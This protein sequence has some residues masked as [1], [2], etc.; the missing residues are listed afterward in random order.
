MQDQ[1]TIKYKPKSIIAANARN[2][3]ILLILFV[4]ILIFSMS[5]VLVNNANNE[6]AKNLLSTYSVDASQI[7]NLYVN[8]DITLVRKVSNSKAVSN[9]FS[10]EKNEEKKAIAYDEMMDYA[11]SLDNPHFY[12]G[13]DE[14]KNQYTILSERTLV[15]LSQYGKLDPLYYDDAWYFDCI[16]SDN[17]YVINIDIDKFSYKIKLWINHKVF[18]N[19]SISGVFCSGLEIPELFQKVFSNNKKNKLQ[20]YVI[21]K[22]GII[23]IDNSIHPIEIF[24]KKNSILEKNLN[25]NF[26]SA[27]IPYLNNINGYFSALPE[28]TLVRLSKYKYEYAAICPIIDTDWSIVIFYSGN[29]FSGISNIIPFVLIIILALF[30]YFAFSSALIKNLVFTPLSHLTRNVNEIKSLNVSFFGSEREDEIGELSR[31]ITK[32]TN[33]QYHQEM[34]LN[35]V[36][37]AA[38]ELLLSSTN[39]E[40]FSSSILE[41]MGHIGGTLDVDRVYIY[42]NENRNDGLYYVKKFEWTNK[43]DSDFLSSEHILPIGTALKYT[44]ESDWETI[45]F[46]KNNLNGPIDSLS[47]NNK[48]FLQNFNIKSILMIPIHFHDSFWGFVGF[49]DCHQ[50]RYFSEDEVNILRSVGLMIVSSINRN[51]Q[52]IQLQQANNAKSSFLARMSHEMRTPLNAIIGLSEIILKFSKMDYDSSTNLEKIYNAGVTLLSTVNHILDISKIEA[53]KFE[54]IPVEYDLPSLLNDSISQCI[55]YKGEKPIKFNLSIDEK[56]PARL[57]GDDL[58]IKQ[59]LNN[60]LSNAFKYTRTGTVELQVNCEK[61]ISDNQVCIV[62]NVRDS[63]IGIHMENIENLFT[64]YEQLDTK[65]NRQIEGTGLG[66]PIT[67]KIVEMMDGSISINSEYGKGSTFTVKFIQK[68]VNDAVIGYEVANNLTNFIYSDQKRRKNST[69]QRLQLPYARVLVVDDVET[70]LDVA[71]GMLRPYGIKVDC[72]S[73]GQAAI[74]AIRNE[75]VIYNSILMDQMMPDMDGIETTRIIREEIG[76]EYAKTIPI[77]ALTANA[78]VGTEESFLNKGFQAFLSKPI[79]MEQLDS[80]INAWIRNPELEKSLEKTNPKGQKFL[81]IRCGKERREISSRR[82][83][84]DRRLIETKV[85]GVNIKKGIKRFNNEEETY[86]KVLRSYVLNARLYLKDPI[87]IS[88]DN[89]EKY[90][91]TM[92]GFKGAS[93]GICADFIAAKAEALEKAAKNMNFD[94]IKTNNSDFEND[95]NILANGLDKMLELTKNENK[96]AKENK[97]DPEALKKLLTAC[98][99]YDMDKV[100]TAIEEIDKY[101]YEEDSELAAWL[102][103]NAE[104]ANFIGIIEK[105]KGGNYEFRTQ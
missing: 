71:I 39:E 7:F 61:S 81:D 16:K 89:L 30:I 56:L 66:L 32:A 80:I 52:S 14:S 54:L 104:E 20:G 15:D 29:T 2:M 55:I 19:G 86:F 37:N 79:N 68:M 59:I 35:T 98:E 103:K 97:I 82:S 25:T 90:A 77:I 64:D 1:K 105:I 18:S 53:G 102:Y 26:A 75:K 48:N 57:F 11:M 9:W 100:D 69:R 22:Q 8:K 83:G 46:N 34:L 21:D 63:G 24:G 13:I 62:I 23:Q 101:E 70:N 87:K 50:N 73:S 51:S 76:T 27:I 33:E 44:K 4:L 3:N 45:F 40:L 95:L 17:D 84:I 41:C 92:H 85:S 47:L 10:D 38:V 74:N 96:K 43:S 60:L 78:I 65:L 91:I 31:A 5:I 36:N 72:L 49:D 12:F 94:F 42:Q 28:I 6:Y 93:L 88:K 99:K 58:R 67:K